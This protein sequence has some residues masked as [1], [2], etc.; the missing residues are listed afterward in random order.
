MTLWRRSG[1]CARSGE[2]YF[3]RGRAVS[4]QDRPGDEL[5][6]HLGDGIDILNP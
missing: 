6:Q 3:R 5:V 2:V 4:K 1:E